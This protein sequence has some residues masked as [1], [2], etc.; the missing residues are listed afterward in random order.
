MSCVA[1]GTASSTAS[2]RMASAWLAC[3]AGAGNK[4]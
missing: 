4:P 1:T 2:A 3:D